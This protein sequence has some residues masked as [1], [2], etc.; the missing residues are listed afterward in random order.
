VFAGVF[1]RSHRFVSLFLMTDVF[2]FVGLE[3]LF[4]YLG[5][6][7]SHNYYNFVAFHSVLVVIL[8]TIFTS[9][10]YYFSREAALLL[11]LAYVLMIVFN[12]ISIISPEVRPYGMRVAMFLQFIALMMGDADCDSINNNRKYSR[13]IHCWHRFG[14]GSF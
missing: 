8:L 14:K 10:N 13:A 3:Y 12:L 5:I 2:L 1:I 4:Q 11:L 9:L 6:W 7:N